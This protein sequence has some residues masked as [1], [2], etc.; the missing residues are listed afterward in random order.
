MRP[1]FLILLTTLLFSSKTF[2]QDSAIVLDWT[3][4]FKIIQQADSL[5]NA[6]LYHVSAQSYSKAF[7]F[8]KQRF[9]SGD[10]YRAAR[11]WAMAGSKDSAITNLRADIDQGYY[12]YTQFVSEKAFSALK[13]DPIWKTLSSEIKSH[14]KREIEKLGKYKPV[15]AKLE[16]LLVLDQKYRKNY[17]DIWKR[18]GNHSKE[19][20]ALQKKMKKIDQ[21]NLNYVTKII[22]KYGWIGYDTIGIEANSALFL[23]IQHADSSTQEK[24]LPLLRK[25][26]KQNK[27]VPESLALLED[28]VLVRRGEK[29][30]YGTQV[31]CDSS[32]YKCRVLPIEDE[33]NVDNRRKAIGMRPLAIYLKPFGIEY[34]TLD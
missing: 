22:D 17:M 5:F 20:V 4:Y 34:K 6:K 29:Q 21:S 1:I 2:G 12:D 23:V 18:F 14:Q 13:N 15:K 3:E 11:A 24:Y 32:G 19:F 7:A 8:N 30:I 31:E 10:R 26:V 33:K 16:Q 28:R 25:A 9:S 27:A